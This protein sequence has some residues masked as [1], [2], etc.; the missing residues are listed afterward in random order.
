MI[1]LLYNPGEA[2]ACDHHYHDFGIA[3]TP[4]QF[5]PIRFDPIQPSYLLFRVVS[6][7]D[8]LLDRAHCPDYYQLLLCLK[9]H[10]Q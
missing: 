7:Y 3:Q 9:I 4:S 1:N 5:A 2:Y 10:R 6:N 8:Y